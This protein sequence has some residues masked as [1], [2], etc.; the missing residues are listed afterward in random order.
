MKRVASTRKTKKK[1]KGHSLLFWCVLVLFLIVTAVCLIHACIFVLEAH[2]G[3][4]DTRWFWA[5]AQLLVRGRNPYDQ[6]AVG[7]L[8]AA[9]GIPVDTNNVLR[10]PPTALFLVIPLGFLQGWEAVPV[11]SFL[12]AVC[13]VIAVLVLRPMLPE[14]RPKWYLWLAFCFAP[15]IC[16]VEVGQTGVIVLLG[17]ALFLRF[18]ESRPLLAG[19]ALSL[20][21]LKPHLLLP[22]EVALIAW[23]IT[24]KK[25]SVVPGLLA[26]MAV[27]SLIAMA[28]DHHVWSHYF[29]AMRT[30]DLTDLYI[31]T[32]GAALRS[33]IDG[34]AVWL[35]FVPAA[36]GCV[37]ALWY[38]VRNR[39]GWDWTTH[40]SLVTLV[41]MVV[42]P[43]SWFT[44]QAIALPAIL[45]ALLSGGKLGRG[46]LTLLLFLMTLATLERLA[47]QTLFFDPFWWQ[48]VA[49]LLWYLY[50]TSHRVKEA[51]VAAA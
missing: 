41:S 11:W 51:A 31:P 23:I 18:H 42:A 10:N 29:A 22:F 32:L 38:F 16:C 27:E 30:Q 12:L 9:L 20:C 47:V 44:D 34:A 35:E 25:W 1:R 3:H 7:R 33:G 14:P 28:F 24:R 37:W 5:S 45:F 48:G 46:S 19:A 6:V 49:W 26:A 8:Q 15:A 17:L 40:G 50:A 4:H 43:Y 2:L 36:A 39:E 13:L 21:A